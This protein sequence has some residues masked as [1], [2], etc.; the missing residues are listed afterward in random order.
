MAK[1]A[2]LFARLASFSAPALL[3]LA[4]I[5]AL[6]LLFGAVNI[7]LLLAVEGLT[8]GRFAPHFLAGWAASNVLP[9]QLGDATLVLWLRGEGV[10]FARS[11]AA[12]LT[13]KA[14]S[15][16]W[17]V[18]AGACGLLLVLPDARSWMLLAGSVVVLALVVAGANQK[19][20]TSVWDRLVRRVASLQSLRLELER[21]GRHPGRLLTNFSITVGKWCLTTLLYWTAF[22]AA[23]AEM[24]LAAVA[25]LPSTCSLV[26]YLPVSVG[27]LG[28]M[29][30]TAVTLFASFGASSATVVAA[31]FV[32]RAVL[33]ALVA[34]LLPLSHLLS[35]QAG[36]SP[37]ES[38][39]R[40]GSGEALGEERG[41]AETEPESPASS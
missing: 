3:A 23:G 18:L 39:G 21:I 33:F 41:P 2:E 16:A 26:G 27:G 14:I 34:L 37:Q 22:R 13:D 32:L 6:W 10:P 4:A 12:Y 11:S 9:G 24:P 17:L 35:R 5:S 7:Y 40:T 36:S 25:T 19:L 20:R 38:R 28:T 29:E 15:F 30:W 8:F 31:Y 1:P